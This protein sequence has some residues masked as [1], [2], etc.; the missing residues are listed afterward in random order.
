LKFFFLNQGRSL[1]TSADG[2]GIVRKV[3]VLVVYY[4]IDRDPKSVIIP[5]W[6]RE[7]TAGKFKLEMPEDFE[8]KL[9][10]GN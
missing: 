4:D 10:L 1:A 2:E 6:F 3:A 9:V 8:G 7:F 5:D